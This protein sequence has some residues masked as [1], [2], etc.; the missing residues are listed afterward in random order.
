MTPAALDE[1]VLGC[2]NQASEDNRNVAGMAVFLS[3]L[4]ETV[5]AV[6]VNRLCASGMD[7]VIGAACA[8]RCG[9]ADLVLAGGVESMP[10]APFDMP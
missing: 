6:T 1:V 10:R 5:P 9:E 7:A 4:P 3:E 2:A 8:L